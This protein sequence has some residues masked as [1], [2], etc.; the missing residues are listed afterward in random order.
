[1]LFQRETHAPTLLKAKARRLRKETG[2]QKLVTAEERAQSQAKNTFSNAFIRPIKLL[3]MSPIVFSLALY[4]A[5]LYAYLYLLLTTFPRVFI[6]QYHFSTGTSGLS[7]IGLGLGTLAGLA[8]TTKYNDRIVNRISEQRGERKPE[9]RLITMSYAGP[10]VPIGLLLYGWSADKKVHWIV[11]QIG[12]FILGA[13][14]FAATMPGNIYCIDAFTIYAASAIAAITI[15]RSV[16]GGVLPL[17][18]E[19]M[20]DSLGLGWGNTLL[21]FIAAL[22][23]P[24]PVVL[25]KYGETLR[26]RKELKL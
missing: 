10:L 23:C 6:G 7:Y 20:Y 17:A 13:G 14:L 16:L 2:N 19:S 12:T 11:P 21:A 18:G 3:F 15:F 1:M 9:Y 5:L 8:M 26:K 22:M 4:S 24:I 25:L